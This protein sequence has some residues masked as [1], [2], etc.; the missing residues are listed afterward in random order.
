MMSQQTKQTTLVA[1]I[2]RSGL[3]LTMQMLYAGG[4]PC[5]GIWPGFEMYS[6][7]RKRWDRVDNYRAG[8]CVAIKMVDIHNKLP[9]PGDYHI[10]RL[11]RN[12]VEQARSIIKFMRHRGMDVRDSALRKIAC[13][14][15]Q[16]YKKIDRWIERSG[17]PVL[18]LHF[19]KILEDPV[20]EARRI[21][22]FLDKPIIIQDMNCV[23]VVRS[24][25]CFPTML[26]ELLKKD[27][28]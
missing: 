3:A 19:E 5:M 15:I 1:G 20:R 6:P 4:Y 10:I 2:P 13:S 7:E 16:D 11:H 26:E 21:Q 12:R 17:C 27:G 25:E 14:T 9:P 8:G 28:Y 18:H 22:R 24:P 23:V